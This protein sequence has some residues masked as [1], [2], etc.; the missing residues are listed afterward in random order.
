MTRR[1]SRLSEVRSVIIQTMRSIDV[2]LNTGPR[3]LVRDCGD[4][5]KWTR[6]IQQRGTQQVVLMLEVKS[7]TERH[8]FLG[9]VGFES[10]KFVVVE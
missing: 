6:K 9:R 1:G 5:P 8:L 2:I 7:G 10:K 3:L 4:L